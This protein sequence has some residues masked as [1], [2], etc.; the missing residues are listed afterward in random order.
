IEDEIIISAGMSGNLYR[1][2]GYGIT[3]AGFKQIPPIFPNTY[4]PTNSVTVNYPAV[5]N[6]QGIPL[7]GVSN[8]G[9]NVALQGVYS[10]GRRNAS[11]PK[12]LVLEFLPS[13]NNLNGLTIWSL[14][15]V[16]NNLYMSSYDANTGTY[17]ID[18]LD[19]NSKFS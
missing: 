5:A 11:Y 3:F 19:W 7:F 6:K 8:T 10:F 15:T 13:T 12:I 17:Q 14:A 18:K 1:M 2:D 4:S 16:N 9:G